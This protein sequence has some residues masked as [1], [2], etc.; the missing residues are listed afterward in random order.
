[1]NTRVGAASELA[2]IAIYLASLVAI[3]LWAARRQRTSD[4]FMA[5]GRRMPG[6]AVGLSI[7]GTYVSSISFLAI[8]SKAYASN[9]NA[10]VFSL[11]IP[12][13]AWIAVRWFVPFYR[14]TRS[15]SSYE[16]L[17]QRFG[18]WARTYAVVCYLLTQLAR[19]G[20][21]M[22]LLALAL[23][24]LTGWSVSTL[25][26]VTGAV[27][28]VY[29][30]VGGIEAVIWTD[31]L[32]SVVFI[33][34]ALACVAVLFFGVPGGPAHAIELAM[35]DRKFSF[36]DW[37]TSLGQSTVWVVLM[38]GIFIN[39][40]NFGIDQTYVQRYQT[41]RSED[42]ARRSVWLGALL[43]VPISA[44]FFLIGTGL[45]VYYASRPGVLPPTVAATPDTVFPYFIDTAL[46]PA[47]A[48]LVLASVFAA[49]Q[50]TISSSINSS[51]TLLLCDVYVRYA[52]P[53]A[54][55]G[56]RLTVLRVATLVVGIG[57]TAAALAMMRIRS[58]LDV[59]WQL[60]GIFSGGMLGLFLL[61]R[62]SRR[63]RGQDA[64]LGVAAGVLIILWMTLSPSWTGS[65]A[66]LRSPFHS[67]L[68]IVFGTTAVLAV[69]AIS[70]WWRS[71]VTDSAARRPDAVRDP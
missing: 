57:G 2:V 36:G 69:G 11:S 28:I 60:A 41:A 62:L 5:S 30:V 4:D 55:D 67:N 54:T 66:S 22:Y 38:Y 61:G 26:V 34:G 29:A 20:T 39:L 3:G 44:A 68:F 63:A 21:I 37:S 24:P 18:A 12:L 40:Q 70:A 35:T 9:W 42:A 8:P 10:W 65:W 19:S 7:F 17:E 1:M 23:A 45:F 16:H 15:V 31:V 53:R 50:S 14:A 59:W 58:A 47:L 51:A 64:A 33:V 32:Q 46:S 56:Q 71:A 25:I 6:W 13:T 52:Q 48:G 49:A 43:Y 27:V